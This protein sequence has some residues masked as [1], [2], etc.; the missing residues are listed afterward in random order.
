MDKTT[1]PKKK[2]TMKIY[3]LQYLVQTKNRLEKISWKM[4]KDSI[5]CV[6]HLL[7]LNEKIVL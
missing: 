4:P 3:V 1:E 5:P 7:I 2:K 6:T